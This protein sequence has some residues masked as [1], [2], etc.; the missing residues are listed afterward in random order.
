MSGDLPS[1]VL[2]PGLYNAPNSVGARIIPE[3]YFPSFTSV[4]KQNEFFNGEIVKSDSAEGIVNSW[5]KKTNSLRIESKQVFVENEVIRGSASRTEGIALS[6]RSYESYLKMGAISKTLRGH[7][8]DSGFLN[9]NMQRIQD[10]DYY[11]TFAYSLSSRVPLETWNDVVSS[12]N[13]TLGYK[14]FADY[15]LESVTSVSV[16]ISTDQTAIDQIIDA[17]GFADLNC[18]Y[19]FDV[20]SENFLNVGDKVL[21]TEIRFASRILQDFLESVGNRVLSIDDLSSQFNSDPRPTAFSVINTFALASRRAMKYITYVR[22]TRFTAQRQLMIVDLIHDG[23][24]GYINQYGRVE[25]TYDQG[26]F[27]FTVSGTDGQLQFFPTK[28][29]VNDYQIAAISYNLDDNLL[30]TG[31]TAIG[32]SIIETDSIT[33]GSGIGEQQRS[34]VSLALII[35]S[36]Y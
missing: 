12:T 35:L 19:D 5:D 18:V 32:P 20:V 8:D 11:Q 4:L 13:H 16:G 9:T 2:S 22:D 30:S 31:T 21:S 34:L 6:V 23:A 14:K 15:Q 7:Q 28:F 3:R 1:G 25:S 10:S 36:R 29:K 24:R 26:S 27:D 33:I 17:V